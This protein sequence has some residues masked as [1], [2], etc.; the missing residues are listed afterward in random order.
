MR[1]IAY[2]VTDNLVPYQNQA[3]EET[4]LDMAHDGLVILYLWQNRNTV[5]IGRNQSARTE[6]RVD[7]MKEEGAYLAR[8]LSGGGAVYHDVGNLN[9]TFLAGKEDYDTEKQNRVIL[10]AVQSFGIMAD[11]TGRNDMLANGRKFSG[12]AYFESAGKCFHHGTIMVDVDMER[13]PR[14]LTVPADK[15]KAKGVRSVKSRVTN[16]AALNSAVT[17][18]K[19]RDAMIR[20]FQLVYGMEA[21]KLSRS[22]LPALEIAKRTAQ[23]ADPAWLERKAF[24]YSFEWKNRFPWGGVRICLD[25]KE[26]R[27]VSCGIDSDAMDVSFLPAWQDALCGRT[28]C[29]EEVLLALPETGGEED[30]LRT[31]MKADLAAWMSEVF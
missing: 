1:Q 14:Y 16:L 3:V 5:V 6:C 31:A 27:I 8:R 21:K 10:E 15:M 24:P 13:L 28:F 17:V 29:K 23:F 12:H 20:S 26:N 19:M 11:R 22:D 2:L 30:E 25:V 7:L 18:D 4:L 9:F